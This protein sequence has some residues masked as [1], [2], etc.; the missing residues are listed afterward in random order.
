MNILVTAR[1]RSLGKVMFSQVCAIL[2][3]GIS[4]VPCSF[5]GVGIS[6]TRSLMGVGMSADWIPATF[7][8]PT[9]EM[10]YNGIRLASGRCASYWNAFLFEIDFCSQIKNE[11]F[12]VS[13]IILTKVNLQ[14]QNF[15][16]SADRNTVSPSFDN[17][18][19]RLWA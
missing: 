4:V 16:R 19:V 13:I 9:P 5:L 7:L 10:G 3:T 18:C 6:G 8:P 17:K 1:Q 11:C 15:Y 12:V 14:A 2:S